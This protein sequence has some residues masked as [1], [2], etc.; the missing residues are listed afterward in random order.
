[1]TN[2]PVCRIG[3]NLLWLR[4]GRVGGTESYA[5]RLIG[6]LVHHAK[7]LELH[8]FCTTDT[9][10][11]HTGSVGATTVH[12]APRG[13]T[14]I[15]LRV[16]LERTWLPRRSD[17]LDLIHHL[18]GT[19]PGR[20][21]GPVV[22]TIHDLQPLDIPENFS[23]TKRRWLSR[24]I[25]AA[26]ERADVIATPSNWVGGTIVDR[27]GIDPDRV[28]TVPAYALPAMEP[29]EPSTQM[30][31]VLRRGPV[32]LY[33]AMTMEHKNHAILFEAFARAAT[34]RPDLQLVCVGAVG[35]DNDTI[36][37]AARRASDR[38]H[39]LG[40]VPEADL[41][42]L[43]RGADALVFPSRYEGFGLPILEAQQL[44]VPVISSDA[45]ALPEVS[46]GAAI[47]LGPDDVD[48][49]VDVM[50]KPLDTSEREDLIVRGKRNAARFDPPTTA[51]AQQHAYHTALERT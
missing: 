36:G 26:I 46:G 28:M 44:G 16:A 30:E 13:S 22:V 1:M 10:G 14:N 11:V 3:L 50:S 5:T 18:G 49:W 29:A 32:L 2:R 41:A 39:M 6:A 8:S 31:D 51:A 38:I 43:M 7:E 34:I 12:F 9:A 27:F 37:M 23:S 42:V 35:R 25:P 45:T 4:S 19:A 47:H 15:A 48:G 24:E 40:H 17:D 21:T 33:P 20:S